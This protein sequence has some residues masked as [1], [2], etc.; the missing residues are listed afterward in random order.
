LANAY[1]SRPPGAIDITYVPLASGFMYLAAT[2]D[3]YS[4]L[5]VARRLSNTSDGSF[6]LEM[7]EE[8]PGKGRPEVFNTDQ[9]GASLRRRRGPVAWRRGGEQGEGPRD[10]KECRGRRSRMAL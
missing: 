7:L 9:G 10:E 6:C 8:A 2:I 5:A 1:F 4:R 3:W